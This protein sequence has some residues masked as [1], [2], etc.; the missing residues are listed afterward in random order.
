MRILWLTNVAFPAD[1]DYETASGPWMWM[2]LE[3]LLSTNNVSEIAIIHS[4]YRKDRCIKKINSKITYYE[5]PA[6]RTDTETGTKLAIEE[7]LEVISDW[8]P[9]LIHVHGSEEF[10][11]LIATQERIQCPIILSL[12]GIMLEYMKWRN[13]FGDVTFADLM[14]M[15][16]FGRLISWR[17]SERKKELISNYFSYRKQGQREKKIL[18]ALS[19]II[20]RTEWDQAQSKFYSPNARYYHCDELLRLPFSAKPWNLDQCKRNTLIFTNGNHPRKGTIQLIEA[21]EKLH[22]DF[23]ELTLKICGKIT[24][25]TSFGRFLHQRAQASPIKIVFLGHLNATELADELRDA[26]IFVSPT[27][28]DNSPNSICEA[29]TIGNPIVASYTGGVPSLITHNHSGLLYPV[30]DVPSMSATI[31]KILLDDN[32]ANR[33]SQNAQK[34][35][36][37]RHS[38]EKIVKQY[39]TAYQD[40]IQHWNAK[41]TI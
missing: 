14:K 10:Y 26:H 12:Q 40:C 36:R 15:H 37:E 39:T 41:K 23:P 4:T 24:D 6:S 3:A 22:T 8:A 19:F 32:L 9:D 27:L 21:A 29:Q 11:G 17:R 30:N 33:L 2:L 16:D 34:I 5:L 1:Q 28:I 31:A 38:R 7:C 13:Y 35:A 25:K 18:E 20:G